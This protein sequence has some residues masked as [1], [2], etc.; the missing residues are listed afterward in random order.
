MAKKIITQDEFV[1]ILKNI[2]KEDVKRENNSDDNVEFMGYATNYVY[3]PGIGNISYTNVYDIDPEIYEAT[4]GDD[5]DW[6]DYENGEISDS[7]IDII[8]PFYEDEEDDDGNPF[9]LNDVKISQIIEDTDSFLHDFDWIQ[10]LVDIEYID[11]VVVSDHPLNIEYI[12]RP[13]LDTAMIAFEDIWSREYFEMILES[14]DDDNA[15][16]FK[17]SVN[18]LKLTKGPFYDDETDKENMNRLRKSELQRGSYKCGSGTKLE[19]L[20]INHLF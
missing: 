17:K 3:V 14:M 20:V 13:S 4:I 1:E 11:N 9:L 16:E 8:D 19:N 15:E 18:K 10:G 12:K 2:K 5:Q 7:E 6:T